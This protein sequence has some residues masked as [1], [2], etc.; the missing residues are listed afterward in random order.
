MS[1]KPAS[2][3][4]ESLRAIVE[5]YGVDIVRDS[6]RLEAL[7]LDYGGSQKREIFLVVGAARSGI[8]ERLI[9]LKGLSPS[10]TLLVALQ[11][12]MERQ[13][14]LSE[15]AARSTLE[16]WCGALDLPIPPLVQAGSEASDRQGWI[17]F[18][19]LP[20]FR[21]PHLPHLRP[22]RLSIK[23]RIR[24]L[25]QALKRAPWRY[26]PGFR[27]GQWWRRLTMVMTYLVGF[28]GVGEAIALRRRDF[29]AYVAVYFSVCLLGPYGWTWYRRYR[30]S[31]PFRQNDKGAVPVA[32]R[33]APLIY[34]IYGVLAVVAFRYAGAQSLALVPTTGPDDPS[35]AKSTGIPVNIQHA[36][37][38]GGAAA[39]A[40]FSGPVKA[41]E[42]SGRTGQHPLW[43]V[44][45]Q[46]EAGPPAPF[47]TFETNAVA[48]DAITG[49]RLGQSSTA[50]SSVTQ[51]PPFS[52]L[53]RSGAWLYLGYG[54][55]GY[56]LNLVE[57]ILAFELTIIF[58]RGLVR[59]RD[60]AANRK[61]GCLGLLPGLMLML[62]TAVQGLGLV[63]AAYFAAFGD[64]VALT[65]LKLWP[66]AVLLAFVISRWLIASKSMRQLGVQ[67]YQG[68][69]I[70]P[71]QFSQ[72]GK[73]WWTGSEWIPA[74]S[75]K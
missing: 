47:S 5:R 40:N 63:V 41:V 46:A 17:R 42:D 67:P 32:V 52:R 20:S 6:R 35:H 70:A 56:V 4:D 22:A 64:P 19:H 8:V 49:Q 44:Y 48:V 58:I 13:M 26:I 54:L 39:S 2:I 30:R 21:R 66:A 15:A 24:S 53:G 55:D 50:Q 25:D 1:P 37:Q 14:G 3:I 60:I 57:A 73:W 59:R 69:S 23:P 75:R 18:P 43:I 10:P 16:S 45:P 51:Q 71:P 11:R 7:L 34:V 65:V 72:D 31:H 38:T 9:D 29:L 61:S 74:A 36:V 27:T 68:R 33:I 28:A 12:Q 62:V